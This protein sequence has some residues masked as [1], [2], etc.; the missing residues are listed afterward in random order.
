MKGKT[1][2]K[3]STVMEN[4]KELW[5]GSEKYLRL[6]YNSN[7]YFIYDGSECAKEYMHEFLNYRKCV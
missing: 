5:K 6:V 1:D 7:G 3:I 2:S 4:L